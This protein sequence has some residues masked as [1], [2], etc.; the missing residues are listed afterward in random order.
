V[1]LTRP[2]LIAR[3]VKLT[4]APAGA[5]LVPLVPPRAAPHISWDSLGGGGPRVGATSVT[6]NTQTSAGALLPDACVLDGLDSSRILVLPP[7]APANLRVNISGLVLRNGKAVGDTADEHSGGALAMQSS[8]ALVIVDHC[9]FDSNHAV[10]DGGAVVVT[11][12]SALIALG[13]RFTNNVRASR[14]AM[15]G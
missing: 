8:R 13:L 14:R 15:A 6:P 10:E 2:L 4:C 7:T 9:T 1:Q 12:S 5:A 3:S 11:R